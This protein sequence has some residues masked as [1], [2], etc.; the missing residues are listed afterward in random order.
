MDG[1]ILNDIKKQLGPSEDYTYFD[2]QI[3]LHINTFLNRLTQL[4][5]GKRGFSISSADSKWSDFLGES[6][7]NLQGVKT[8]LYCRVKLVFDPP[9][10]SYVAAELEKTW[11]ELEWTLNVEV[12]PG[13]DLLE[14][15][16]E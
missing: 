11:K 8:Y 15:E 6:L 13:M 14:G 12:D 1:S 2:D 10:S 9:Q 4:G 7:P 3:M 16:D 5:V